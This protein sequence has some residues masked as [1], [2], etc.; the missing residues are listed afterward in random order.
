M[1]TLASLITILLTFIASSLAQSV[2]SPEFK[3]AYEEDWRA[4]CHV[5][6]DASDPNSK[7]RKEMEVLLTELAAANNPDVSGPR[8][9][10]KLARLAMVR[11][12][13]RDAA[14]AGAAPPV[15][16]AVAPSL[17]NPAG[18]MQIMQQEEALAGQLKGYRNKVTYGSGK[19]AGKTRKELVAWCVSQFAA[20]HGYTPLYEEGAPIGGWKNEQAKATADAGAKAKAATDAAAAQA[21]NAAILADAAARETQ[22]KLDEAKRKLD[23]IDRKLRP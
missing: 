19:W 16:A 2:D 18:L 20:A 3:K 9:N 10:S 11:I 14:Q 23:N 4:T 8:A 21:R 17:T 1:K 13:Q 12:A 7:L 22:R 5:F 15:A 6:P